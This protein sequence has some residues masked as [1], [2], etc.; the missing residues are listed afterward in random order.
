MLS[1]RMAA[2]LLA[3]GVLLLWVQML[4]LR[5]PTRRIAVSATTSSLLL[6]AT[7]SAT[8][9][10]SLQ[11]YTLRQRGEQQVAAGILNEMN[12]ALLR[13][14]DEGEG[15]EAEAGGSVDGPGGRNGEEG[16]DYEQ[17][18]GQQ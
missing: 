8:K 14:A 12:D 4:I 9:T 16:E 15:E 18:P 17:E 3:T 2:G 6:D 10:V 11:T 5:A 1:R 13:E 7:A